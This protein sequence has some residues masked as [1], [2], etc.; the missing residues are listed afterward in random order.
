ML[1]SRTYIVIRNRNPARN[2]SPARYRPIDELKCLWALY[3]TFAWNG[4][5][6]SN[7]FSWKLYCSQYLCKFI[8]WC[9][10][11]LINEREAFCITNKNYTW[12]NMIRLPNEMYLIVRGRYMR[13]FIGRRHG[14]LAVIG[15]FKGN[16]LDTVLNDNMLEVFS[17]CIVGRKFSGQVFELYLTLVSKVKNTYVGTFYNETSTLDPSATIS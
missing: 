5:H 4:F 1:S 8:D 2:R 15:Y 6:A 7:K 9:L 12:W 3:V 16:D 10:I 11:P 14:Y 13:A 17:S